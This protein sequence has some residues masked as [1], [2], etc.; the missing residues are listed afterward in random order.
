MPMP[1]DVFL[2]TLQFGT[3][4]F[5]ATE[6]VLFRASNYSLDVSQDVNQTSTTLKKVKAVSVPDQVPTMDRF[7]TSTSNSTGSNSTSAAAPTLGT[8]VEGFMLPLWHCA[9]V[10]FVFMD[11][12]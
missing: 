4:T 7:K 6:E 8:A 11:W 9:I 12:L 10:L 2:G 3:E 1:E 5:H